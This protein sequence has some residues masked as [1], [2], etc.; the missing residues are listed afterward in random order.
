[1]IFLRSSRCLA[2]RQSSLFYRQ[3]CFR[4]SSTKSCE[5]LRILFCGS[6]EIS[7]ASLNALH[8]EHNKSPETI[9]SIDVVCRPGKRVGRGLKTIR[10][11]P[12]KAA[13][14]NLSLPV[15]E[16]DTF[17]GWTPPQSYYGPWNLIVAVSFGLFIPSRILK[18]AKY[19]G[20]NI[21]PS[22][23]PDF[24]GP[25]PIHRVLL[26][27]E[28]KTGVTLQ[29][30][31]ESKFDHG[32]ILDQ[33][34]FD[35]PE[36]QT[37]CVQELLRVAAEKGA[38]MLVDG[39]RNRLFVPPLE[40]LSLPPVIDETS[41]RHAAKITP[42]DRHV[43]WPSWTWDRISRYHRIIGPLWNYAA[44]FDNSES[45]RSSAQKRIIFTDMEIVQSEP[46]LEL[47]SLIE[48]GVPFAILGNPSLEDQD[49]PIYVL[50][51]D[52][53]L[54]KINK[55]KVEGEKIKGAYVSALKAKMIAPLKGGLM[56]KFY[57]PLH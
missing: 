7:I 20:L 15:H 46:I 41:L 24:R 11:V 39:I 22:L 23:L 28:T 31:H 19:G 45:T 2:L 9:A 42:E 14:K 25:A 35:T 8:A 47:V 57:A 26:A 16:V 48:P 55:T 54:V 38:E 56:S 29:T 21:H 6:D 40:P 32:L 53:K 44:T 50:T 5:P 52:R 34:S 49:R 1:M 27:E 10:E 43:D 13:A 30:L 36:S 12:I 18:A 4:R 3:L 37:G 17:T 33:T 51:G